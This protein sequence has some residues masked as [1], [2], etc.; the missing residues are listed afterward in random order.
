M[1]SFVDT[2]SLLN[3][4][5]VSRSFYSISKRDS[6]IETLEFNSNIYNNAINIFKY[7]ININPFFIK[8]LKFCCDK[9]RE[10]VQLN[11]LKIQNIYN[12][13]Y[14]K[15]KHIKNI[16]CYSGSYINENIFNNY[17]N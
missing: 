17:Q 6:T 1:F 14:K 16:Y 9:K 8:S 10:K 15:L 3:L 2:M 7:L 13:L 12:K 11:S 4:S 5:H